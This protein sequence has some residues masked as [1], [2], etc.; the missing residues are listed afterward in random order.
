MGM[1]QYF[2]NF[3]NLSTLKVSNFTSRLVKK[4]L[5]VYLLNIYSKSLVKGNYV[6][7]TMVFVWNVLWNT[8]LTGYHQKLKDGESITFF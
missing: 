4:L 6:S 7:F 5:E 8:L 3:D 2:F 1:K